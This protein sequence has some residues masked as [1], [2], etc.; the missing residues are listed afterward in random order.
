MGN[1]Q[2]DALAKQT[3]QDRIQTLCSANSR[4]SYF[5]EK[6][7]MEQ[8]FLATQYLHDVSNLHFKL[9]NEQEA[10]RTQGRMPTQGAEI[11]LLDESQFEVFHFDA[12]KQKES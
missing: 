4:W 6:H 10:P 11:Q 3:L 7:L 2:A 5:S 8:A 12:C 1:D 9:R